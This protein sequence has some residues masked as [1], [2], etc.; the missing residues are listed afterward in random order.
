MVG[1]EAERLYN[2]HPF[3]DIERNVIGTWVVDNFL[4]GFVGNI[5]AAYM[6]ALKTAISVKLLYRVC[7]FK[8]MPSELNMLD[9]DM[10]TFLEYADVD[11][12]QNA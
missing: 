2:T 12:S 4:T 3:A 6:N 5:E 9:E 7:R 11:K 1:M 10:I 8:G